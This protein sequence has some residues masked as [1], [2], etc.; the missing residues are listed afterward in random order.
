MFN[1]DWRGKHYA[2]KEVTVYFKIRGEDIIV[3]TAKARYGSRFPRGS[4]L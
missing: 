1:D 3:L 4:G 2:E